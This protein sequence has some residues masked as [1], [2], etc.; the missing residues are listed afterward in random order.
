MTAMPPETLAKLRDL[1]KSAT[2]GPWFDAD[3]THGNWIGIQDAYMALGTM[4]GQDDALLVV[5]MR[6]HLTEL[7]AERDHLAAI[8][9]DAALETYEPEGAEI[10][11][12]TVVRLKSEAVAARAERD[13]ARGDT[14]A[15]RRRITRAVASALP[16]CAG[17]FDADHLCGD[18]AHALAAEVRQAVRAALDVDSAQGDREASRG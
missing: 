9:H 18:P 2:Q 11:V 12:A 17:C 13:A 5:T 8:V 10:V 7:I 15:L 16:T 6:N 3:Q 1:D 14:V 4:A